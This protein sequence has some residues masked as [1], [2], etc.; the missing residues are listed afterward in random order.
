MGARLGLLLQSL[1]ES[2]TYS[3]LFYSA[4]ALA[5]SS[6]MIKPIEG[7]GLSDALR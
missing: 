5:T 1:P 3:S 6:R 2:F 7:V 4:T